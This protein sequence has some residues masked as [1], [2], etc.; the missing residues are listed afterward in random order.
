[1]GNSPFG[2]FIFVL[3]IGAMAAI[4]GAEMGARERA[5][6]MK[7]DSAVVADSLYKANGKK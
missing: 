7:A 3:C 4:L 6:K 1:M 5:E 2:I